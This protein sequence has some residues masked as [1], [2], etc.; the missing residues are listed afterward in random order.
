MTTIEEARCAEH[1]LRL[2]SMCSPNCG[3]M[4]RA[5]DLSVA[6][7]YI[8]RVLHETLFASEH[9][10][11]SYDDSPREAASPAHTLVRLRG[12]LAATGWLSEAED[13]APTERGADLLARARK[14]GVL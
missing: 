3:P 11:P 9:A 6:D 7:I 8:A 10:A 1:G 4:P 2:C 13:N 14:A 5:E 12:M